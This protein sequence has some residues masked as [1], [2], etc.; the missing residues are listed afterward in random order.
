MHAAG[1]C[2]REL[3]L[4]NNTDF[5]TGDHSAVTF[6]FGIRNIKYIRGTVCIQDELTSGKIL[7]GAGELIHI[8]AVFGFGCSCG[9]R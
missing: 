8:N 1:I 4:I 6:Q 9:I 3:P 5:V 7:Q 2:T